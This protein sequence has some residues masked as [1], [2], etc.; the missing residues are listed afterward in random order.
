MAKNKTGSWISIFV[1]SLLA[2]GFVS[3]IAWGSFGEIG[4]ILITGLIAFAVVFFALVVLRLLQ[5]DDD[6]KPGVPRLK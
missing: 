4:K 3:L 1:I 6:V 2:A 5:K